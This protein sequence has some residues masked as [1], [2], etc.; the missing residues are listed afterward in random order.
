MT[1]MATPQPAPTSTISSPPLPNPLLTPP[2][3]SHPS[4]SPSN[5]P[6]NTV[7]SQCTPNL[8]P[9]DPS[10]PYPP[11]IL[12]TTKHRLPLRPMHPLDAPSMAIACA[13]A[14]ITEYMSLAFAHPYTLAHAER[15]IE[16]NLRDKLPNYVFTIPEEGVAEDIIGG[17]GLKRGSDVH[18]HT[19]ELGYWLAEPHW[20]KGYMTDVLASFIA[21]VFDCDSPA[22]QEEKRR[23]NAEGISRLCAMVFSGNEASM[24][25]LRKCGFVQEGVLRGHVWKKG[26]VMDLHVFGL[27]RGEWLERQGRERRESKVKGERK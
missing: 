25:V 6:S 20:R 8:N 9:L 1:T 19:A 13:P 26:R 22:A 27:G 17:I 15:W 11:P 18:A 5:I 12:H 21:W 16:M 14:S 3:P 10:L 4:P 7:P 2:A 23:T 24:N